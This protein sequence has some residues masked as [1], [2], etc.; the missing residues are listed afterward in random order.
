MALL[1]QL[2]RAHLRQHYAEVP[3]T[4]SS[5]PSNNDFMIEM[6]NLPT[7]PQAC[8]I[9]EPTQPSAWLDIEKEAD[10]APAEETPHART[11]RNAPESA[12]IAAAISVD[13]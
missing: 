1:T 4:H 10:T 2:Q 6:D 9:P 7:C 8:T 3:T 12:T 5:P 13:F 11:A